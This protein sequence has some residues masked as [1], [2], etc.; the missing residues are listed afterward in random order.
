MTGRNSLR[1]R[2]AQ[3]IEEIANVGSMRK[4]SVCEQFQRSRRSDGT[5]SKRG[6][7]A[8]YTCKKGGKTVGKRLWPEQAALYRTQIERFRK[9]RVLCGELADVSE[10]MADCE[11]LAQQEGK[12]NS[13]RLSGRSTKR[14]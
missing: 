8:M 3:I 7:Y 1:F 12:R 9:F 11:A 10:K 2:R 13:S 5:I 14:K 4:G 6:P